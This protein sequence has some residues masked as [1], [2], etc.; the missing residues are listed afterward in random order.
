MIELI[1]L[2]HCSIVVQDLEA[3]RH[4]YCDILGMEEVSRP[5]TF[6]FA[7]QWFR[8]NGCEVHT[9]HSS[10][11]RQ[12]SGDPV[13]EPRAD[14]PERDITFARH[15]CFSIRNLDQT[16][17]T[18][19][20]HNISLVSPPRERGDGATQLYLYDPDGHMI[21]LVYEPFP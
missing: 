8:K 17:Q 11:A 4:F 13:N 3:S 6:T 18:L 14:K 2:H 12:I 9:I 1:S 7:G 19:A 10:E 15:M 16:L 5:K 20:E 21:E